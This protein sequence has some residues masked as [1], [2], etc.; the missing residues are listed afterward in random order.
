MKYIFITGIKKPT[1]KLAP[2]MK[3]RRILKKG[4][5]WIGYHYDGR[6]KDNNRIEIALGTDLTKAKEK[7]VE[8]E[9]KHL[10]EQYKDE[11]TLGYLFDLYLDKGMTGLK[12]KT[13]KYCKS[14]MKKLRLVFEDAPVD[15]VTTKDIADYRDIR[16]EQFCKS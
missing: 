3:I 7:W 2:R 16:S 10:P 13:I 5:V 4:K 14:Y 9:K 15:Q 6:D 8:L 1:I 12:S 11:I